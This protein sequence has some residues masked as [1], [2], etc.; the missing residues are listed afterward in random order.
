MD[1]YAHLSGMISTD[2]PNC[3]VCT[4]H[5]VR[6]FLHDAANR[7]APT[8]QTRPVLVPDVSPYR[9][10]N[11][12]QTGCMRG[13][14]SAGNSRSPSTSCAEFVSEYQ[15]PEHHERWDA[16]VTCFFLD[17][18]KNPLDYIRTVAFATLLVLIIA[19]WSFV[20][21]QCLRM[22]TLLGMLP[23]AQALSP[24]V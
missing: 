9:I 3:P 16:V 22:L 24:I 18:A 19:E 5:R 11:G 4:A 21:L 17:T 10:C 6:P 14:Q 23:V 15:R 12:G 1:E 8:D 7:L 20:S 2:I 13:T